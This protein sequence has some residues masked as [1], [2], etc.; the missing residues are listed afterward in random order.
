[1]GLARR[2]VIAETAIRHG[3]FVIED[4][5]CGLLGQSRIPAIRDLAPEASFYLTSMAKSVIPALRVGFL[6]PP[7][8]KIAAVNAA[9][10]ATGWT[11][12]PLM[13]DVAA[14]M[15]LDGT[16]ERLAAQNRHEALRR[17]ELAHAVLGT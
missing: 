10:R 17:Q 4:D 2:Q 16:A 15:I 9:M 11:A 13:V 7:K 5:I 3:L 12:A 14:R 1:M 8:G 6:L